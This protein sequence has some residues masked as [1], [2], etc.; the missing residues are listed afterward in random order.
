MYNIHIRKPVF[1]RG[2]TKNPGADRNR[3][4]PGL[5][6]CNGEY[7]SS[8]RVKSHKPYVMHHLVGKI[9]VVVLDDGGELILN[10]NND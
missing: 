7:Y 9:L 8:L 4:T 1:W 3:S 5:G 6:M 10:S 2:E